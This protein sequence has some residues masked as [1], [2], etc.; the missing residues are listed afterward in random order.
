MEWEQKKNRKWGTSIKLFKINV[1][2]KSSFKP[3][4]F[5]LCF[6][7]PQRPRPCYF[8]EPVTRFF[9]NCSPGV[10][11]AFVQKS[12][13]WALSH[14]PSLNVLSVGLGLPWCVSQ[15]KEGSRGSVSA[16]AEAPTHRK[17]GQWGDFM[18]EIGS[19]GVEQGW[20]SWARR[21]SRVAFVS[22]SLTLA[23][24]V[25]SRCSV[26]GSGRG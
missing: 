23:F 25:L 12:C 13:S 11:R 20:L 3:E 9:C 2:L 18:A 5:R 7:F 4:Q 1:F 10:S 19:N 17:M 6:W 15:L 16:G 22:V 26:S 21:A 14:F 8:L 24:Y